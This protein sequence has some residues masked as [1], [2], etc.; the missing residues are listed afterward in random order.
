MSID[1]RYICASDLELALVDKD[2]GLPLAGGTISFYSDINRSTLK[3][4]FTI[5]G[6]PPNYSFVQLPNPSILNGAGQF[7]DGTGN[8]VVPYYFPFDANG[9]SELYYI[10]VFNSNS[11]EQF[12]RE[13]WPPDAVSQQSISSSSD[14]FNYIPNGQLLLHTDIQGPPFGQITQSETILAQGGFAF[15]R[16]SGTTSVDNVQFFRYP[17]YVANPTG[18][19]RYACQ[20]L[21]TSP[22]ISDQFKFF[23]WRFYDVNKFSSDTQQY[24]FSFSASTFSSGNFSAILN[25]IKNFGTG[26]SPSP[27]QTITITTFNITNSQQTFSKAF[28]FG[29]NNGFS[30]GTNNDDYVDVALYVPANIS[31]GMVITDFSLLFG[32]Q[33]I[34]TFPTTTN[35]DFVVRSL[36]PPV[37]LSNGNDLYLQPI[38]T[39]NGYIY[40]FSEIGMVFPITY[41]FSGSLHPTYNLMKLDGS[42]Y[43][44]SGYSPL[45]IP[46]SRLQSV[47]FNASLGQPI[48]GTGPQFVSSYIPSINS[49]IFI[50]TNNL[51]TSVI[52]TDG[53]SS[54][55]FSFFNVCPGS[56]GG[57]GMSGYQSTS[58]SLTVV[59]TS[60]NT[61]TTPTAGT[62]G[63]T[64][65]VYKNP[66]TPTLFKVIFN[67][68]TIAATTLASKYFTFYS[69]PGNVQYYMW[70][71]VDGTGTDPAPGGTGI[72][73]NLKSTYSASDVC[74]IVGRAISGCQIDVLTT[75]TAS[76]IIPGAYFTFTPS[77]TSQQYAVWY[78]IGGVGSAP[79]IGAFNIEVDLL[80]TDMA[81]VVAS[82]TMLAINQVYFAVPN[83]QGAFLRGYD[84]NMIWDVEAASRSSFALSVY[85]NMLGTFQPDSFVAH[86]HTYNLASTPLQQS[87]TTTFCFTTNVLV[88]TGETGFNENRPIDYNVQWVTKY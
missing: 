23:R 68:T 48:Y 37:P 34:T 52:C 49:N 56:S 7:V 14:L 31:V 50:A 16:P 84:P 2:T 9:N 11:T 10:T 33:E 6:S 35:N 40:D 44:T 3:P 59:G 62:S 46:F 39:Q 8:V 45:G 72:R 32:E 73:V 70:F 26:G 65:S 24:T 63:F 12:T 83:F 75:I 13:A 74:T 77:G 71:T 66:S 60:G 54:T 67:I 42:Q 30:L 19:P 28:V 58:T 1:P 22:N 4:I 15:E 27:T 29:S 82:K 86:K 36:A 18:S 76:S 69:N 85:G 5:S 79:S 43:L 51:G 41:N 88:N 57:F 21:C 38:L 61:I 17:Q 87:G 81:S 25:I 53:A 47:Y 55:G 20:F 78:K 80:S 64:V